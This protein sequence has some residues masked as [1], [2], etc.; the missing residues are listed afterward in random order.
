MFA[1]VRAP[2]PSDASLVAEA[3]LRSF[4]VDFRIDVNCDLMFMI[5]LLDCDL[6]LLLP[7]SLALL[8]L[9]DR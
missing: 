2:L 5:S 7:L 3:A 8:D 9:S 1:E 4:A 6:S